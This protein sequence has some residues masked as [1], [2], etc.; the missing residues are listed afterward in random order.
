MKG[1]KIPKRIQNESKTISKPFQIE[2]KNKTELK[3]E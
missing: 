2:L 1:L 3:S